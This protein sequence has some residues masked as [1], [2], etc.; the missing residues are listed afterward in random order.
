MKDEEEALEKISNNV[1]HLV[2]LSF[3]IK[4]PMSQYATATQYSTHTEHNQYECVVWC[5]LN[6]RLCAKR[7]DFI[8]KM[9][10]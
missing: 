9:H 4:F 5:R 1:F 10:K 8:V 3:H 2:F 6:V 7:N